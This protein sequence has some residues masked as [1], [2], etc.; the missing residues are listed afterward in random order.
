[1]YP[2]KYDLRTSG[3][4]CPNERAF[5]YDFC[6]QHLDTPRGRQHVLD[7]IQRGE[8]L[9]P[10]KVAAAIAKAKEIPEEDYHT[11]AL[12][13]MAIALETIQN[14][15][16]ESRSNLD[17]LGGAHAWRWKDK[18]NQEVQHTFVGI[19]ER[20]MDRLSKHLAGMS[21]VSLQDKTV[22]L[23]KAQI[24]MMIRM[25]MSV[26]AELR[27]DD[28]RARRAQVLLLEYMEREANLTGRVDHYA[29]NQ[30]DPQVI[31]A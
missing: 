3:R 9:T 7:V 31:D 25:V 15:V 13:Q 20:A 10:S 22:S 5:D 8:L 18:S 23:G 24:D 29:R 17:S 28:D 2:C 19:Y 21:K 16:D 4:G 11:S 27:L 30:L 14:W 6:Q 26:V 12:E 1:M